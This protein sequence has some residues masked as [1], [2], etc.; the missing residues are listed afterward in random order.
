MIPIE[1]VW[2]IHD[3]RL[4]RCGAPPTVCCGSPEHLSRIYLFGEP[5]TALRLACIALIVA[6][7]VGLKLVA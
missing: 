3:D 5:A 4:P 1:A 2:A 6:G 7:I